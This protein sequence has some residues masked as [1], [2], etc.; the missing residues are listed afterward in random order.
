DMDTVIDGKTVTIVGGANAK[1]TRTMGGDTGNVIRV[2]GASTLV[3][4]GLEVSGGD[5]DGVEVA[6]GTVTIASCKLQNNKGLGLNISDGAVTVTG[7]VIGGNDDGGI[8]VANNRKLE[9]TNSFIVKNTAD[10]GLRMA[11]PGA[12]SKIEFNTIVDNTGGNGSADAGGVFCDD[13]TFTARYNIIF[14]NVGGPNPGTVQTFGSCKFENSFIM[15]GTG[16]G[17]E[18][19]KFKSANDYHLTAMSPAEVRDVAGVVCTGLT[20]YDG[21]ARPQ[22]TACDLG[23]DEHK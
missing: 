2:T 20:D 16:A 17:D 22:G 11:K 3:L 19:L 7:T 13:S 6:G 23:A 1:V 10:G 18:R 12:G 9:I 4:R 5:G 21:D 14:R 8:F 15:P